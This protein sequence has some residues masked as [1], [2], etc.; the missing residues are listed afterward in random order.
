MAGI[1]P[2][3]IILEPINPT[4][5]T[6]LTD[7]LMHDLYASNEQAVNAEFML[8]LCNDADQLIGGLTASTSY[9]WMLI[10]VLWVNQ[11]ER[12]CGL[13]SRLMDAA[14]NRGRD[15]GCHGIWL[16]TS[17]PQ[18]HAFYTTRGF[19]VFGTLSNKPHQHP[20]SHQR[21]MMRR[22]IT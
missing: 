12:R 8:S 16:D 1:A 22:E 11:T 21:W 18:A 10:K 15:L 5:V 13:G 17:N 3:E 9:G 6:E 19:E 4:Q 2:Y 7:H 14:V 20:A